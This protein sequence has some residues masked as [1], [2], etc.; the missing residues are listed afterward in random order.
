MQYPRLVFTLLIAGALALTVYLVVDYS[1]YQQD[2][3]EKS[4]ELGKQ[5]GIRVA[6]AL[7][8]RLY[9]ISERADRYATEVVKIQSKE[10]LL[11]SIQNESLELPLL[12]GVTVAYES[13]QF[14]GKDRYAPFFNKSR[15]EFQFVSS[16]TS[17]SSGIST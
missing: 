2:R 17:W 6:N 5:A 1:K 14:L 3:D 15:N 7:D 4:I 11:E 8:A 13:G 12:L 9:A 10:R 16:E